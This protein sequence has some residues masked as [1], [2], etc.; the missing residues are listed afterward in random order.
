M[1]AKGRRRQAA[2]KVKAAKRAAQYKPG[3]QSKYARKI[4]GQPPAGSLYAAGGKY[5]DYRPLG[6]K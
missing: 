4:H 1:N 5:E 6:A 3:Q 2:Q